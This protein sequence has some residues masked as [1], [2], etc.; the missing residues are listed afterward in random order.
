MPCIEV[1]RQKYTRIV[2]LRPKAQDPQ[3]N[4]SAHCTAIVELSL[5]ARVSAKVH[6]YDVCISR[7]IEH[8]SLLTEKYQRC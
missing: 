4:G 1:G 7:R 6:M 3:R 8:N 5:S 2:S